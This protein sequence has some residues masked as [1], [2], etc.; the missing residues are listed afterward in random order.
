MRVIIFAIL[1]LWFSSSLSQKSPVGH[2]KRADGNI[3]I[4]PDSTFK[5]IYHEDMTRSWATGNWSYDKRNINFIF[6]PIYDTFT[7]TTKQGLIDSLFLSKDFNSERYD[8]HSPKVSS[9]VRVYQ[10][11][12]ECPKTL[13]LINDKLYIVFNGKRLKKK[14]RIWYINPID[15]FFIKD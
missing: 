13:Q 3:W 11:E 7:L 14:I 1:L 9:M 5:I 10:S 2:Y 4:Y 12:K 8:E 15:P 6:K